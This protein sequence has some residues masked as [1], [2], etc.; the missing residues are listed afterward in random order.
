M[1]LPIS[2]ISGSSECMPYLEAQ[3]RQHTSRRGPFYSS[4]QS[5]QSLP[6]EVGNAVH[7]LIQYFLSQPASDR[8]ALANK[9][10]ED[11]EQLRM[12]LEPSDLLR[13]ALPDAF[14]EQGIRSEK[15]IKTWR[16]GSRLLNSCMKFLREIEQQ[17]PESVNKWKVLVE[18][19]L[20]TN[21]R[22]SYQHSPASSRQILEREISL[23]GSIDLVFKFDTI[24]ILGELKTGKHSIRKEKNWFNQVKI[25]MNVWKEKHDDHTVY[26]V[27][28]HP[29]LK[30]GRKMATSPYDFQQLGNSDRRVGGPQCIN[31]NERTS[32]EKSTY[33][34]IRSSNF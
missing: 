18:V 4:T 11:L 8:E 30:H 14:F 17:W 10:K 29:S 16:Y 33:G 31:C 5:V 22:E 9:C 19:E 23:H 24:R 32:C 21:K 28:F 20:H 34:G 7:E 6:Q 26:G 3:I 27:V 15:I 12:N 13:A 1:H 25:Y 2:S